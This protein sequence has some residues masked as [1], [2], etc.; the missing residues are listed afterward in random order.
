MGRRIARFIA[1][2]LLAITG[3]L[4]IYNGVDERAN[5]YSLFQRI[6]YLG[7]VL[8]GVLGLIGTYGV[9]RRRRW[10]HGVVVAWALAV[11]FVAGTAAT[12]YGGPEVTPV[13]AISGGVG[14][15]LVGAFVIWAVRA[16]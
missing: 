5:H 3:A 14:A 16:A 4:G 8:Y 2:L 13:A 12:A 6:V 7:V 10:S 1:L 9:I 15:A 11:T